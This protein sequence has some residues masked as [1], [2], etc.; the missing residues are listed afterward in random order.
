[1]NFSLNSKHE[2]TLIDHLFQNIVIKSKETNKDI[3][4]KGSINSLIINY[5]FHISLLKYKF[6]DDDKNFFKW[7]DFYLTFKTLNEHVIDI[8]YEEFMRISYENFDLSIEKLIDTVN[9]YEKER[10]Y[11]ISLNFY[12]NYVIYLIESKYFS[13]IKRLNMIYEKFDITKVGVMKPNDMESAVNYILSINYYSDEDRKDESDLKRKG[14]NWRFIQFLSSRFAY[15]FLDFITKEEFLSYCLDNKE[16]ISCLSF[17][18]L[19]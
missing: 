11:M 18:V 9:K 19:S 12:I 7:E 5:F 4:Y 17:S 10:K 6:T 13:M 1:M 16:I 14:K 2:M 15:N 8:S 3:V